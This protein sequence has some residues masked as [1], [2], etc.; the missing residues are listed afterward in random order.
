MTCSMAFVSATSV[1]GRSCRC[2]SPCRA[3]A[4][5]RVTG[6][7]GYGGVAVF[8]N[9]VQRPSVSNSSYSPTYIK[10]SASAADTLYSSYYPSSAGN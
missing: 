6:S 1:P 9:D 8:D 7:Y 4:V 3:V 2:M 5:S 10:C